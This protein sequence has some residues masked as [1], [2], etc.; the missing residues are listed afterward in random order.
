M[1]TKTNFASR[2]FA[3]SIAVGVL[4]SMAFFYLI[5]VF[6]DWKIENYR[7]DEETTFTVL[8]HNK[9]AVLGNIHT[10][11]PN[12]DVTEVGEGINGTKLVGSFMNFIDG[13]IMAMI[14]FALLLGGIVFF[15]V[16]KMKKT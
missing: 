6:G 11:R 15:L 13:H 14:I 2:R 16:N 7:P 4:L 10:L 3:R 9:C 5:H 8:L 1:T 12:T